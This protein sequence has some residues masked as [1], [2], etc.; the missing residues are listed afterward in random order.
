MPIYQDRDNQTFVLHP[1]GEYQFQ[2]VAYETGLSMGAKTRGSPMWELKILIEQ[3]GGHV[4]E[5]LIDHEA[6]SWKIDTFLK[7][8]GVVIA[9]GS[10]FEFD[11]A[12]SISMGC[13]WVNPVGLRGWCHLI[14]EEFTPQGATSPKKKNKVGAFLTDKPKLPRIVAVPPAATAEIVDDIPF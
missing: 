8:T 4:F 2:V 11:R 12:A 13:T 1:P 3:K 10:A 5:S 7:S 9:K 14:V 6:C